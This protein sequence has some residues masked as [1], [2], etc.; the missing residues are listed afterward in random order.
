MKKI[1]FV[2]YSYSLGGGAEKVLSNVV[3]NLNPDEY[4]I[5]IQPYAD[6]G[7][8]KEDTPSRVKVRKGIVDMQQAGRLEKGL[9]Y[10]LVHFMPEVLRKLYIREKYDLEIS[11]NY[12]IPSFLVKKTP[13]TK[14]IEWNHGDVYDLKDKKIKRILQRRSYKKAARIVAISENTRKSICE[15]FPE[16]RDK[17]ELIYNGIDV[18]RID[19]MAHQESPIE[20]RKHSVVFVGRLEEAKKPLLL[21]EVIKRIH[22]SGR[23]IS[24]YYLGQGEQKEELLEKIKEWELEDYV[25]LLGYQ[26]NPYPVIRQSRAVCM[27]SRSEGFPTV[28]MEGM[29]LG[30]PFVSSPVGGVKELGNGGRCGAI[31]DGLE[32]CEKA[33]TK[34]VFDEDTNRRMGEACRQHIKNYT[35]EKQKEK[36]ENLLD[37]I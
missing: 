15:L 16:F 32:D 27:L 35:M 9:K 4:D 20:L 5:T 29:A 34:I 25:F 28:F 22:Q 21:L 23:K 11:F 33:I 10:F 26:K 12:Q 13:E 24:L 18:D 30:I 14:V 31:V 7:V 36:I 2:I 8:K 19:R 6:Y 37:R 17:V 1:L 3:M